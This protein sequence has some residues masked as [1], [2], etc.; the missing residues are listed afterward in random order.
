MTTCAYKLDSPE[1]IHLLRDSQHNCSMNG[2][3]RLYKPLDILSTIHIEVRMWIFMVEESKASFRLLGYVGAQ[4]TWFYWHWFNL[5]WFNSL[6]LKNLTLLVNFPSLIL[7]MEGLPC[8]IS[9]C[10][11]PGV[12]GKFWQQKYYQGFIILLEETSTVEVLG[13]KFSMKVLTTPC[14][15]H[16]LDRRKVSWRKYQWFELL[17]HDSCM[18]SGKLYITVHVCVRVMIV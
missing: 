14:S 17:H 9:Y 12:R 18:H 5:C 16:T 8:Q 13:E 4:Q 3:Q 10:S 11:C 1:K 6:S 15:G 7:G 2:L